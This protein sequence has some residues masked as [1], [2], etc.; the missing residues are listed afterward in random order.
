MK[1]LRN[2]LIWLAF[3]SVLN[4]IA[5]H[6]GINSALLMAGGLPLAAGGAITQ[7]MLQALATWDS[8]AWSTFAVT[9]SFTATP[10]QIINGSNTY[11]TLTGSAGAATMTTPTAQALVQ[12]YT[13]AYGQPPTNG[14]TFT[15]EISNQS[16]GTVTLAGGTGVTV[17]GT[18]TTAT[19]VNRTYLG[20]FTNATNTAAAAAVTLQN[21]GSRSN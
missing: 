19:T 20:T 14:S 10:V 8:G 17:N 9:G 21:L 18:A 4:A 6:Y 2:S 7:Q 15:I 13:S 16:N 5:K 3:A 11:L 12:Q 1:L